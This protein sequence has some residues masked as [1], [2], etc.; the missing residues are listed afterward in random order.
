MPT[1]PLSLA[2]NTFCVPRALIVSIARV[3]AAARHKQQ[4]EAARR[5]GA[6]IL[7]GGGDL[8]E[9]TAKAT[10][11]KLY[12]G[13]LGN[14]TLLGG[15][16]VI[17]DCVGTSAT[18]GPALRAARAGGTVVLVGVSLHRMKV[19]LTPTWHQEVDLIGTLAHGMEVVDGR[20]VSTF[21]L[22]G[23]LVKSGKIP[24]DGYVTHR[25]PLE[26]WKEAIQTAV[27]KRSGS[28][29]VMIEIAKGGSPAK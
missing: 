18:L 24:T 11:A 25:F 10:G 27:D 7:D 28:V 6:E 29:K 9:G 26:R 13:D 1:R 23:E 19:D 15:F 4:V 2:T 16:D 20:K 5:F 14:R 21:D 12:K 3:F 8:L 22:T 17:Y